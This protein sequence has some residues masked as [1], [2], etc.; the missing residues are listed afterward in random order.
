MEYTFNGSFEFVYERLR[1]SV[2]GKRRDGGFKDWIYE[3]KDIIEA[4]PIKA[5]RETRNYATSRFHQVLSFYI[6]VLNTP[7]RLLA[8]GESYDAMYFD[9]S[10]EYH[11][12]SISL[13]DLY[14]SENLESKFYEFV[15]STFGR[16]V[17]LNRACFGDPRLHFMDKSEIALRPDHGEPTFAEWL[18]EQP[19]LEQQGDGVNA[20][21]NILLSLLINKQPTVLIDEPEAFLH[22]PQIRAL[23]R[24]IA[25]ESGGD[26]Q[27]VISTHSHDLVQ[28]LIDF[29]PERTS[30]VRLSR[31]INESGVD[32]NRVKILE[33]SDISTF[34]HDPLIRTS[35]ALSSLF[36][37]VA[38][39]VEGDSDARFFRAMVDAIV[40]ESD[41]LLDI[42][43]IHCGGKD[44]IPKI[45]GA[46]RAIGVPI[47]AIVDIDV[48]DDLSRFLSL[49][50]SFGGDASK[51]KSIVSD[52]IRYTSEQR[53]VESA[54]DAKDSVIKLFDSLTDQ[55]RPIPKD[56]LRK[57]QEALR[58]SSAWSLVKRSGDAFFGRGEAHNNFKQVQAFSVDI[59]IVINYFGELENLC[60]SVEARKGEWLAKVL[61][62]NLRESVYLQDAREFV[63]ILIDKCKVISG[64]KYLNPP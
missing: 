56:T 22:P 20:F 7:S 63:T 10:D 45:A 41:R 4:E 19:T 55:R 18:D 11:S 60:K 40:D 44:R 48:L 2:A 21:C 49:V 17:L 50:E 15:A 58:T 54:G 46:L 23:A 27:L 38:V 12:T 13:R 62:N 28:G 39:I 6:K 33:S 35:D 24:L 14:E 25:T 1:K 36:H 30:V 3:Q 47:V 43:F 32:V 57:M 5:L 8:F 51:I 52:I 34:W 42:R 26:T 64:K 53:S 31:E 16:G 61:Q 37:H 9:K 59:G 29:A